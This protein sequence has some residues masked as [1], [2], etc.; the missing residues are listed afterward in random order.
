MAAYKGDKWS[1]KRRLAC[2]A[3]AAAISFSIVVPAFATQVRPSNKAP[4][5]NT[6]NI[7]PA[8]GTNNTLPADTNVPGS[9]VPAAVPPAGNTA[10]G[11]NAQSSMP[12]YSAPG[13]TAPGYT[14]PSNVAPGTAGNVNT[15]P[16]YAGP[17]NT[18]PG[19]TAPGNTAP[20]NTT[21]GNTAPGNTAPGYAAPGNTAPGYAAPGNTAPGNTAPGNTAPGYTAPGNT[22]PGYAAP[23][24]TAP[25]YAAPGNTTPGNTAPGPIPGTQRGN[26]V[27]GNPNNAQVGGV[28]NDPNPNLPGDNNPGH[29]EYTNNMDYSSH[30]Y[31]PVTGRTRPL[32]KAKPIPGVMDVYNVHAKDTLWI[33]S[34]KYRVKL[35]AI[36]D[37][38]PELPD[39]DLIYPGDQIKVPL[40]PKINDSLDIADSDIDK[41]DGKTK[42]RSNVVQGR[43]AGDTPVTQ[44]NSEEKELLDLINRERAKAGLRSVKL[45]ASIGTA[46]RIKADEMSAKQYFSH[47][48][49]VYGSPFEML[50]SFGITYKTAGENIAK[51]QKSANAVLNAWMN[52]EG[53]RANILNPDFDEIGIGYASDSKITYWVLILVGK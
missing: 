8:S 32:L 14:A 50:R 43:Y 3:I 18:A 53:H 12:G 36:I 31:D 27:P 48:S 44:E 41:G 29:R 7:G 4:T 30:T 11:N 26:T 23:G 6:Q 52:S 1:M 51:G 39:P 15:A 17:G 19:Y 10:P 33:I 5:Q 47:T 24:N 38:N 35:D 2:L 25:G 45:C 22:A 21:P 46:A 40:D 42:I 49:P 13:N 16:G 37:A 20:G 34:R 28:S 9:N